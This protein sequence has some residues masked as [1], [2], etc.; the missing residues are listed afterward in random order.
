[1]LAATCEV[2]DA[3]RVAIANLSV[4]TRY[5]SAATGFVRPASCT[6]VGG[7]S[8]AHRGIVKKRTLA[9]IL[10]CSGALL[11]P[12]AALAQQ[13][14][15]LAPGS[16]RASTEVARNQQS[17]VPAGAK[18][19]EGAVQRAVKRFRIGA[20]GGG[21]IDPVLIMFGAH[22]AFAPIISEKVEFRPGFEFGFGEVTT[23]FGINL[24]VLYVHPKTV[25]GS[26]W[27]PYFGGG[28]NFA[29]S[30]RG[31]E[32][33]VEEEDGGGRFDFS[34]SD[35]EGGFNVIAGLRSQSGAF[36]EIS[37]TAYSVTVIRFLVGFNF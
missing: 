1:L 30:H 22:G 3:N 17:N 18:Q 15:D 31:F 32:A 35:F 16:E 21:G 37:A 23:L 5:V 9:N 20:Q 26:R 4:A 7:H 33:D 29:L 27:A 25:R 19:V 11:F 24:D 34:D 13:S 2:I 12:G 8:A 6:V 10:V 28:A 14:S 36:G